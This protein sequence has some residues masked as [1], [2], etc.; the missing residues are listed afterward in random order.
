MIMND[1]NFKNRIQV[2]GDFVNQTFQRHLLTSLNSC[3]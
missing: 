3:T 2:K 1:K